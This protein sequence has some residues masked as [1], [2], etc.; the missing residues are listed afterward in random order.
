MYSV[1]T[2]TNVVTG[3]YYIG[4]TVN[5]PRRKS[6]H[7]SQLRRGVH[8]CVT[9][10]NAFSPE[11]EENFQ[12]SILEICETLQEAL[13]LEQWHLDNCKSQLYNVSPHAWEGGDVITAHPNREIVTQ[14]IGDARR[15]QVQSLTVEERKKMYG[16]AGASNGRWKGAVWNV[17]PQC[18]GTKGFYSPVCRECKKL[19]KL[20]K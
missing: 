12:F 5:L 4:H 10:Q 16:N 7:M 19:N 3:N 11:N 18:N 6:Q 17:C 13:D 14:H 8:H 2:I 1:Y 20:R 9:L 15:K